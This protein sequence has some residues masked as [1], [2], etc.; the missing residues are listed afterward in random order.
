MLFEPDE[1]EKFGNKTFPKRLRYDNYNNSHTRGYLKRK[2]NMT[3]DWCVFKLQ[4]V[5]WREK[6]DVFSARRGVG[7]GW[8]TPL[9]GLYRPQTKKRIVFIPFGHK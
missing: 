9:Y 8:G 5:V 3:I 7:G 1:F 4:G 6:F 2:S